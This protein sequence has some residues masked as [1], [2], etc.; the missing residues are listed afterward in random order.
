[1]FNT[2]ITDILLSLPAIIIAFAFHEFAHAF[3]ADKLGDD[4]PRLQGRLTLSPLVHLDPIGFIMILFAGFGWAK[5]VQVNPR[6]FKNYRR[7]DTLVSVAGPLANLA[8]A[9]VFALITKILSVTNVFVILGDQVGQNLILILTTII[10]INVT[11]FI[12]NILPIPPL[13]GSSILE[14][15]TNI[16]RF[17]FYQLIKRYSFI[18]VI[19]LIM[20]HVLDYIILVPSSVIINFIYKMFMLI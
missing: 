16:D 4:T 7:D 13:D 19:I 10:R 11:L 1:M 14:N 12:F 17:D 9:V 15:L 2:S 6:N 18:I 3:V 20:T 5:P 8:I